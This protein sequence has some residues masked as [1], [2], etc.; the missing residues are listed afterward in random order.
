MY[1]RPPRSTRTDTPFPYTTL[2][3]SV[4]RGRRLPRD[5][6]RRLSERA[7]RLQPEQAAQPAPAAE[8]PHLPEQG[9]GAGL[10]RRPRTLGR[11][12]EEPGSRRGAGA[13]PLRRVQHR[14]RLLPRSSRPPDLTRGPHPPPERP[15]PHYV[16]ARHPPPAPRPP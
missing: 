8:R 6:P 15:L 14:Q 12:D 16:P 7:C 11:R 4:L 3:R 5:R 13:Q 2:V 10:R 9:L 1:S